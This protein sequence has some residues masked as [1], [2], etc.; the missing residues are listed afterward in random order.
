MNSWSPSL[1]TPLLPLVIVDYS[2]SV[3]GPTC[4][5]HLWY[6]CFR[7]S[8]SLSCPLPLVTSCVCM[9]EVFG[10]SWPSQATVLADFAAHSAR[11]HSHILNGV[12]FCRLRARVLS[13]GLQSLYGLL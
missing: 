5:L 6:H 4:C 11:L 10:E 9:E 8:A 12:T 3:S 13:A 1:S 7:V 2:Q